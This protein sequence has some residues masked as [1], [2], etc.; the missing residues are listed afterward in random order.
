MEI[1]V[2][3]SDMDL[4]T[5]SRGSSDWVEITHG[6]TQ[7]RIPNPLVADVST[8]KYRAV[9]TLRPHPTTGV[10]GVAAVEVDPPTPT[11]LLRAL[12]MG[13]AAEEIIRQGSVRFRRLTPSE[14]EDLDSDW[15]ARHGEHL[16]P[17]F[18]P[19]GVCHGHRVPR[20]D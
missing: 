17:S 2:R 9:V 8:G 12:G 18:V 15:F 13:A 5:R 20:P 1:R 3:P 4:P 10:F 16:P 11:S 7:I 14:V 19:G 6:D